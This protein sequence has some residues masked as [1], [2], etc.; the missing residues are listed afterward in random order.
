MCWGR[1]EDFLGR[2]RVEMPYLPVEQ[3][4]GNF[5][6]VELGLDEPAAVAEGGR[7]FQCGVRWQ[8][9]AVPLPPVEGHKT[10]EIK[11]ILS[12]V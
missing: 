7:C 3:R 10:R 1:E 11:E 12:S 6:E 4:L 8:V 5:T 9:S 2:A